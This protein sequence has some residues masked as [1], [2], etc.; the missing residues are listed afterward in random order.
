M[1]ACRVLSYQYQ[2]QSNYRNNLQL[3]RLI[4]IGIQNPDEKQLRFELE[5]DS[6]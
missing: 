1:Y 2:K 6:K 5:F 3:I 4:R